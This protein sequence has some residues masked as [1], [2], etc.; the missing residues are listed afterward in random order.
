MRIL[1]TSDLHFNRQQLAW[2]ALPPPGFDLVVIAGDLLD[3]A[4]HRSVPEQIAEVRQELIRL[5]AAGP[6]LVASGNHDA[7]RASSDGEPFAA[8]VEE[9]QAEGITPDGSG[10]D[11]GADRITV[12]PWWN[13][14]AQRAR[15]LSH[16]ERER[17]LVRGRWI[18]VHHAPPRGSRIAWTRRGNAGDPFLSRLIGAHQP[19]AV[20]CGH[21]HEAPFHADGAWCEQLG[22]TWVF[23]PGRQPGD[24]P[25]WIALDLA[26]GTAEYRNLEGVQT[27]DLGWTRGAPVPPASR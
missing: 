10:R 1:A 25:A 3:L 24:V 19:T 15:L 20:L 5:R 27:V 4:G 23:N 18:W 16:L 11:L 8:W 26:A 6:V 14:P 17:T 13:G 9:L 21:I 12:F 2:V 7:D 22:A